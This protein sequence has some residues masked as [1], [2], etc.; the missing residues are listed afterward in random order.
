MDYDA[1]RFVNVIQMN[2]PKTFKCVNT[3]GRCLSPVDSEPTES[4]SFG[5]SIQ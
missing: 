4:G 5:N 1:D 3:K 2:T